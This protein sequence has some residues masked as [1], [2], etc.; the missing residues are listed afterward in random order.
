MDGRT[1]SVPQKI[2]RRE[3]VARLGMLAG[4]AA[5]AC[6]PLRIGLRAYPDRYDADEALVRRTLRAFADTVVPGAAVEGIE[7]LLSDPF[8]GLEPYRGY[9]AADLDRRATAAGGRA[10]ADLDRRGR[11]RVVAAGTESPDATTRKLYAGAVF[12]AQIGAFGAAGDG[13]GP[14][15]LIGWKGA[16]V[17]VA[18]PR[19][20]HPDPLRYLPPALTPD[21]NYA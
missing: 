10:F 19:Q 7:D 16:G 3:A 9:L 20:G 14:C 15:S 2:T 13:Q 1:G 8:Y 21:G 17:P 5:L 18:A 12:L 6:T 4:L 11:T